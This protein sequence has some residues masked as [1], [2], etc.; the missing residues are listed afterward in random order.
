VTRS[1]ANLKSRAIRELIV[2]VVVSPQID[3]AEFLVTLLVD[4]IAWA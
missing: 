4:S 2:V 1:S 3:A